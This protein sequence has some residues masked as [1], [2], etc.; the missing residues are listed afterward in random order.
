MKPLVKTVIRFYESDAENMLNFRDFTLLMADLRYCV[1]GGF[2]HCLFTSAV[3]ISPQTS[4]AKKATIVYRA[5]DMDENGTIGKS[6]MINVYR[7]LLGDSLP[8]EHLA[9]IV[10]QIMSKVDSDGD[11]NMSKEEFQEVLIGADLEAQMTVLVR[12]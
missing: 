6:E 12:V 9:A 8:E 7:Q 3:I 1:D 11:G 2:K 4:Y 10:D 5:F